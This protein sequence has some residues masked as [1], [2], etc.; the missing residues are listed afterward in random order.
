MQLR[1]SKGRFTAKLKNTEI[2]EENRYCLICGCEKL[3]RVLR[4]NSHAILR[5]HSHAILW[6]NSYAILRE[7]SHAE[8]KSPYASSILKSS[9]AKAKNGVIIGASPLTT[10]QWLEGCGISVN[11]GKVI[12][13]KSL[14]KDWTSTD[15]FKFEVG[16]K[17][18][19]PDWDE[20][21]IGECGYGIHYSPT[22]AQSLAFRDEGLYIACEVKVK[23]IASLP[24]FAQY[25]DK[26]RAKGGI[27]LYQCDKDGKEIK[28]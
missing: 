21:F 5:G 23:D 2:K 28:Q 12:L 19:A 18:I 24:A 7:N 8:S 25:P 1:D 4:E 20:L 9:S 14:N 13:Y 22:V 27:C 16:K 15:G 17:H 10:S 6:E 3:Y 26:I 11:K